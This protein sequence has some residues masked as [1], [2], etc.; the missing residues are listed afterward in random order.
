MTN[1]E[2]GKLFKNLRQIN[3]M[4]QKELGE[5]LHI[6]DKA[7]SKWERGISLPD[8]EMINSIAEVFKVPVSTLI[9]NDINN[10]AQTKEKET[11]SKPFAL[12]NNETLI[13]I[14]CGIFIIVI[15]LI[16]LF[17]ININNKNTEVT[18]EDL[19]EV[20]VGTN[21][22]NPDRIIYKDSNNNYY[23]FLNGTQKYSN[24][25]GLLQKSITS[26]TDSGEYLT[27]EEID[28]IHN[29]TSFIEFDYNTISKNYII[30]LSDNSNRAVIR[31]ADSGGRV[32]T[33]E[34]SN[35]DKIKST[36]NSLTSDET[37]YK[38]DYYELTSEN[39]L[40]N[41][42]INSSLK[43]ISQNIYQV[44]IDNLES[45][46]EYAKLYDIKI[47]QNI[48]NETFN[49]YDIILT[50]AIDY[51]ISVKVNLGN[52]RYTYNTLN[53]ENREFI[54]HL[55]IVSKIV[56][57][58]CIYNTISTESNYV[59]ENLDPEIFVTN[60]DDFFEKYDL[61]SSQISEDQA[62][63]VSQKALPYASASLLYDSA[64]TF[65]KEESVQPND[66]FSKNL[67]KGLENNS[68]TIDVYAVYYEDEYGNGLI[69]YV[70]KKLGMVIGGD[71][72]GI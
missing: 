61:A 36:L 38:L 63:I 68:R 8:L 41:I 30:Q 44:K 42:E 11:P 52:I 49:N 21:I 10:N 54:A 27:D 6:T 45:Y 15:I 33:K 16:I 13:A 34:I 60:L 72:Y 64:T 69:I 71:E 58:D 57:T 7:I 55:L 1:E 25:K 23:E 39:F 43:E 56:N 22:A 24:I 35:L 29:N 51:D 2:F 48:D 4:T 17:G 3:K 31:L 20:I 14:I 40:D 46:E 70:D 28:E 67:A 18:S 5:K 9:D 32:C 53:S 19:A 62:F 65:I 12:K 37:P 66:Y 59:Y 26:Y 50:L 47:N